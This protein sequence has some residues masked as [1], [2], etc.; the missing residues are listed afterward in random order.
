MKC[1]PEFFLVNNGPYRFNY[2]VCKYSFKYKHNTTTSFPSSSVLLKNSTKDGE[3][4]IKYLN[5]SDREKVITSK[6]H[7]AT[8]SLPKQPKRKV[9][10]K[11]CVG[12]AITKRLQ[13]EGE[14]GISIPYD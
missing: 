14:D 13:E 1:R 7:Q 3:N 10:G 2:E 9:T 4:S 12:P 8:V 11:K 5:D 6:K